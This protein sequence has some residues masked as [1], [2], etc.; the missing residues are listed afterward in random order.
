MKMIY[1]AALMAGTALVPANALAQ[2][3]PA[4]SN[5]QNNSAVQSTRPDAAATRVQAHIQRALQAL[6]NDDIQ[7]AR[8]AVQEARGQLN[9]Q[10]QNRP[11]GTRSNSVAQIRQPLQEAEQAL[12]QQNSQQAEEALGRVEEQMANMD[13]QRRNATGEADVVVE[14]QASILVDVPEPDVTVQQA[15]PRV[16]VQQQQPEITV[17][18]PAPTVTVNIPQPQI[19]VRMPEPDVQVSQ[20]QPEVQVEQG[21]PQVQVSES[22]PQVR[23]QGNQGQEQA[24]VQLQRSGEPVV[25]MQR[26]EQEPEIRYTAEEAQVRVNRA[27]GEPEVRFEQGERQTAGNHNRQA[28]E[29]RQARNEDGDEVDRQNTAAISEGSAR[30]DANSAVAAGSSR[31]VS[32]TVANIKDYDIVGANGNELGDIEEVVNVDNRL[33]A[34]VTSGGFLGL[35]EN[36]AAVPLSALHVTDQETLEAPNVT[37]RQI[38]GMENFQSDRY[39]AL[40]DDHPVT[41]GAR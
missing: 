10:A 1:V 2:Q 4:T 31:E 39:Q 41:L 13:R 12:A 17:H 8:Q 38:E 3:T 25:Q 29:E 26:S 15:N 9:Q 36:R 37:E 23:R 24:N 32:L 40:P 21:E 30:D 33:Y 20:S 6:D 27:E 35:G 18:Q 14:D 19:T 22:Q 11:E 16:S 5:N 34:V 7:A 28:A